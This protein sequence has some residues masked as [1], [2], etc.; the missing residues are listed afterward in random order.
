MCFE[1]I[2][3]MFRDNN[4]NNN[5]DSLYTDNFIVNLLA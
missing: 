5:H 4:H 3:T 2:N 1:I